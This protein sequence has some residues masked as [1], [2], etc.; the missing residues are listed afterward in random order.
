MNLI[1]SQGPPRLGFRL[2][3]SGSDRSHLDLAGERENVFALP[4]IT[5]FTAHEEFAAPEAHGAVETLANRGVY[6]AHVGLANWLIQTT[7]K[8]YH[9]SNAQRQTDAT[10]T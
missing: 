3:G 7:E 8:Q 4:L 5:L 9:F 10:L 6:L 1:A 2:L